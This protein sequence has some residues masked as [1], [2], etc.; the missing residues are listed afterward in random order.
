MDQLKSMLQ[1]NSTDSPEDHLTGGHM[2]G[3]SFHIAG[4]TF[5]K[6]VS[7]VASIHGVPSNVWGLESGATNRICISPTLMHSLK[8]LPH[9]SHLSLPNGQQVQVHTI[10]LAYVNSFITLTNAYLVEQFLF[11]LLSI[12]KFLVQFAY[13]QL[14]TSLIFFHL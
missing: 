8:Q 11:N 4:M 6:S 12:S 2:A 10:G 1:K 3:I 14:L 9:P 5:L 7:L 13:L